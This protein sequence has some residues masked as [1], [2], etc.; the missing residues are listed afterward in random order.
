VLQPTDTSTW[1]AGSVAF[2]TGE[3]GGA[4]D[5]VV[6]W[7]P[8]ESPTTAELHADPPPPSSLTDD[9]GRFCI[10]GLKAGTTWS[11]RAAGRGVY[12]CRSKA[13]KT[14]AGTLDLALTVARIWG[15]RVLIRDENGD[16][17]ARTR[18]SRPRPDPL[19]AEGA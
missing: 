12:S 13:D 7:P 19:A 16:P 17:P 14:A 6:A 8:T 18:T 5:H 3:P 10:T 9:T 1:I 15:V 11:V 4:G 2:T